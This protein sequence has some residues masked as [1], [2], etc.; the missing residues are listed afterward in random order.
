MQSKLLPPGGHPR[1]GRRR[2]HQPRAGWGGRGWHLPPPHGETVPAALAHAALG[3]W[4]VAAALVAGPPR[5]LAAWLTACHP[6]VHGGRRWSQQAQSAR[7]AAPAEASSCNALEQPPSCW[8]T[9]TAVVAIFLFP[10]M[11][12]RYPSFARLSQLRGCA[13][14]STYRPCTGGAGTGGHS[15]G[16]GGHSWPRSE[17]CRGAR[18]S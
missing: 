2:H 8:P 5:G 12:Q 7:A 9:L 1:C 15:E 10:Q 16:Q 14:P 17:A 18:S 4:A 13:T 6:A 11:E 3:C